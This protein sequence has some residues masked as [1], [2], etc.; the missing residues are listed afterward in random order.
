MADLES[1]VNIPCM[2]LDC[3]RKLGVPERISAGTG[4]HANCTQKKPQMISGFRIFL[5]WG[6]SAKP[7]SSE[8]Q[9]KVLFL[10]MTLEVVNAALWERD[11]WRLCWRGQ[12]KLFRWA[13]ASD[14]S[15][16][17]TIKNIFTV[18]YFVSVENKYKHIPGHTHSNENWWIEAQDPSVSSRSWCFLS[19]DVWRPWRGDV[20]I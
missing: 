14:S 20:Q 15:H 4:Q 11:E 1:W 13:D 19:A 6:D 10:W 8:Q 7:H 17:L 12:K 18:H 5:L 9:E 3:G 16:K 2:S